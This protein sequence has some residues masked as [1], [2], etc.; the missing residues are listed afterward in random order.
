LP[1]PVPQ[2]QKLERLQRLQ[3]QLEAQAGALSAAMIGSTQRV[4]VE[5]PSKKSAAELAGRTANN[6][7][8]NFAGDPGLRGQFV[9]VRICAALAHT[10]RG[11]LADAA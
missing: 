11:E 10:L 9:A 2:A 1:D 4:L 6:R 7:V 3:A 5:G 8:V